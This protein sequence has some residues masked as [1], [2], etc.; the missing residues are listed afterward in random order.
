MN[1]RGVRF[2]VR[3][4]ISLVLLSAAAQAA[5]G[6]KFDFSPDPLNRFRTVPALSLTCPTVAHAPKVD[7]KLTDDVWR[8]AAVI[9][10]L[11]KADPQTTVRVCAD[12]RT[13]YIAVA[14]RLNRGRPPTGKDLE[15]DGPIWQ[16]DCIELWITPDISRTTSYQF[17]VNSANSFYDSLRYGGRSKSAHNPNWEHA[18]AVE[19]DGWNLEMAIPFAAAGMETWQRRLGFN[20]GRN[21]PG[22][23]PHSWNGKYGDATT[24]VL[25]FPKAPEREVVGRTEQG[26][27][28]DAKVMTVGDGLSLRFERLEAR[29]GERWIDGAVRIRSGVDPKRCRLVARLYGAD[30]AKPLDEASVTPDMTRGTLAVDLRRHG[31]A[32][33]DLEVALY[34]GQDCIGLVKAFLSARGPERPLDPGARIPVA[35]DVPDGIDTSGP[36]PVTFGVPF[37]AGALW[38]VKRLRVVDGRGRELPSQAEAVGRWALDGAVQWVRFDA[39]VDAKEGCFV[40]VAAPKAGSTPGKPVTVT[41][42]GADLVVDTGAAQYVLA[43]GPSPIREIRRGGRVVATSEGALGLYLVDQ[44]GN[45]ARASAD[46]ED[47]RV[48]ANGPVAACVRFEGSYRLKDGRQMGRHITR[49]EFAAGDPVARVTHTFTITNDTNKV[50]FKDIGWQL[51]VAPGADP[52]AAFGVARA[53]WTKRAEQSVAGADAVSMWQDSHYVFAHGTNHFSLDRID[54]AGKA[55]KI[56]EG[57]ECGDWAS[58]SGGQG[59]LV[60]SCREAARQHPKEFLVS[61]GKLTLRLFSPRGGQELDFRMPAL[62]KRWDLKTWHEKTTSKHRRGPIIEKALVNKSNAIGWSKTHYL[63][64]APL[65]PERPAETAARLSRLTS[66]Q[67]YAHA[68]PKWVCASEAMGPIH[69]KDTERFPEAETAIDAAFRYWEKRIG[70]WGD[71]GFVDYFNGPHLGYRGNYVVQ[72]RYSKNTYTLKPDL[73]LLYARSGERRIRTFIENA[74]R[75]WMDVDLAQWDGDGRIKGICH[76]GSGGDLILGHPHN[77]PMPWAGRAGLNYSSTTNMNL[78]AW[79]Y[80]LAGNRRAKDVMFDFAEGAKRHWTPSG[81]ARAGRSLMVF[82]ALVQ[83]YAFTW[84]PLIRAMAEGTTDQFYDP[85]CELAL[86][87]NRPYSSTYKTQVDIRAIEDGWNILGGRRY[88]EMLTKMADRWWGPLLGTWPHFYTNPQGR[89]GAVLFRDR[90]S[91]HIPQALLTQLRYSASAYDRETDR[92]F[93]SQGAHA[94]TFLFEGLP[95]AMKMIAETNCDRKPVAS[96]VAYEDFGYPTSIVVWKGDEESVDVHLRSASRGKGGAGDILKAGVDVK[97]VA[98]KGQF[99]LDLH[100][101]RRVSSGINTIRLPKDAPEGGYRLVPRGN[102][103]HICYADSNSPMVI[104]APDYWRPSPTQHPPVR[105]FFKLPKGTT[106]GQIFFEGSASLFDPAGKP[107]KNGAPQSGWVTLPEDKPG[108]WHF[109]PVENDIVSSRNIPPFFALETASNYFEP[110]IPWRKRPI[111][112]SKRPDP[113]TVYVSGALETRGNQ[114]VYLTGKRCFRLTGGPPHA[115]GDGLRVLPF[116][117]GTIEFWMKPAWHTCD[118][119]PK[120]QKCLINLGVAKGSPWSVWHYVKPRVRD[121]HVDY[122]YSHVL[123]GWFMSD[124]LAKPTTLRRYRRTIFEPGEWVHVAWVWGQEDGIIPGNPPYHTKVRDNVLVARLFI[125]GTQGSTTGYRWYKN[126]PRDM[127]VRLDIGR[128]YATA[129]IDAAVDELRV[130][131]VQRYREDFVPQRGIE[132]VPD[133]HTRAL[134]HFNGDLAGESWGVDEK[135]AGVLTK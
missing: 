34:D 37:P 127:P 10:R 132:F 29:P 105:T 54:A 94:C 119:R 87:K 13:L 135:I 65:P 115:S 50:W 45:V 55:T 96:W 24:S 95:Y 15:R 43:A 126:Q 103:F 74:A 49:L 73:W 89:A 21:G 23:R 134:F 83:T 77:L 116:K 100:A 59:G 85:A 120:G 109:L 5:G 32:R 8:Q 88:Y 121:A 128:N 131:D 133:E 28:D 18:T 108:L 97:L 38:D 101:L 4:L 112:E 52:T 80:Y 93:G 58:L 33:A 20:I 6:L 3:V 130:S 9:E 35:V 86:T 46:G 22:M 104:H 79:D 124:G 44:E 70:A 110:D 51:S 30:R 63:A 91:A 90:G 114:A 17:V 106:D 11:G 75:T 92:T 57:E 12:E 72:K 62:V 68:D 40:E 61:R 81:A 64:F 118:L 84:D 111:T 36:W 71:Y 125:N 26:V 19:K 39:L 25:V 99:G 66:A 16:D 7:G 67:V 129:N 60:V 31:L 123:Y 27:A 82:R 48:E 78:V 2:T 56:M 117:Q 41:K 122:L 14:C 113:K 107:W 47:V 69:P 98:P 1:R 53:D 102:G 76:Q 42:R